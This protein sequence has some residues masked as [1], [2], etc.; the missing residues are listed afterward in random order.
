[1]SLS[2]LFKVLLTLVKLLP[3]QKKGPDVP[4]ISK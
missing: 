1:M 2:N 3:K 4:P